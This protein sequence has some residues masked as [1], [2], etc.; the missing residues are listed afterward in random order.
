MTVLYENA[1]DWKG[2]GC[3]VLWHRGNTNILGVLL[4]KFQVQK[5]IVM[6]RALKSVN[7]ILP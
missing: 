6:L 1:V 7:D 2:M 3:F 5:L 4:I